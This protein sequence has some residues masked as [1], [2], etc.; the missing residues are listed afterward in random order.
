MPD[1]IVHAP[2]APVALSAN[3]DDSRHDSRAESTTMVAS[4]SPTCGAT[5]MAEGK[6][7]ELTNFF[8]KMTVAEDDR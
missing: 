2:T 8:K 7:L 6:I 3:A 1:T 4:S 5:K